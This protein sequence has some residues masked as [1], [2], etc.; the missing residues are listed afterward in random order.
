MYVYE[1]FLCLNAKI[2]NFWIF[3]FFFYSE[4]I[5]VGNLY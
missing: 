3:S 1:H 5:S 4:D 2:I